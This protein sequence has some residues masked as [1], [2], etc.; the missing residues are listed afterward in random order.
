MACELFQTRYQGCSH[1]EIRVSHKRPVSREVVDASWCPHAHLEFLQHQQSETVAPT[2]E[3]LVA[4]WVTATN[5]ALGADI[6]RIPAVETGLCKKC[7]VDRGHGRLETKV[8]S[9][10]VVFSRDNYPSLL[11]PQS[12]VLSS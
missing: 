5:F 3:S 10:I 9:S 6:K 7:I 11:L 2:Q 1:E 4:E 12:I 8:T